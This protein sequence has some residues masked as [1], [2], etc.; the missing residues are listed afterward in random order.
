MSDFQASKHGHVFVDNQ[1]AGIIEEREGLCIF[2]YD[3]AYLAKDRAK[4]VSL[5]LPLRSEPYKEKNMIPF[6]DGLIPE[7]WLLNIITDNWK[8]NPRDR[9]SLLMLACKDCIGN[10]SVVAEHERKRSITPA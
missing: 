4:P 7:G 9:M 5:T 10:V 6:F 3:K 8:I 1:L 2:T